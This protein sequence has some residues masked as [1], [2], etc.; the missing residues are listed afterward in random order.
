MNQERAS[1]P[2]DPFEGLPAV[3]REIAQSDLSVYVPLF[4]NGGRVCVT[5]G[6]ILIAVDGG[7]AP[8]VTS[9]P[10]TLRGVAAS[11]RRFR[12]LSSAVAVELPD[13]AGEA[14]DSCSGTGRQEAG[15]CPDCRG[16]GSEAVADSCECPH[17]TGTHDC[18]RC[19]GTGSVESG[20]CQDCVGS[21][22]S[23]ADGPIDL[24]P[25]YS[26]ARGYVAKLRRWGATV[27]PP[28]DPAAGDPI[29]FTIGEVEGFLMPMVK[30]EDDDDREEDED[31][32]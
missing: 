9:C 6:V 2:A 13:L 30:V 26:V 25:G 20:A 10:K 12:S 8:R 3:F 14:C 18:G 28:A 32:P 16:S 15:T 17:C 7:A 24:I 1:S 27:Y 4:R 29:R 5:N 19:D 23:D 21:G 31:R 22:V 11:M